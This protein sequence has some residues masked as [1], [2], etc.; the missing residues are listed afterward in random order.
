HPLDED[1][2][3]ELPLEAIGIDAHILQRGVPL[4]P[5]VGPRVVAVHE[6]AIDVENNRSGQNSV[7]FADLENAAN[8]I[9]FV[10]VAGKAGN[11]MQMGVKDGLPGNGTDVPAKRKP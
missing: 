6:H 3:D 2:E 5:P 1:I 7:L 10:R 8:A 4:F 9:A 11:D